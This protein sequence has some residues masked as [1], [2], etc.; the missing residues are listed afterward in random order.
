[1]NNLNFPVAVQRIGALIKWAKDQGCPKVGVMG[2]CMGGALSFAAATL[3]LGADAVVMFY[4]IPDNEYFKWSNC[5]VPV[6]GHFGR[7][8]K[9]KGFADI[10]TMNKL[11][12]VLNSVETVNE[13]HE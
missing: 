2:F 13:F 12:Q 5:K 10:E 8:D 1:M 4:G 7:Y 11:K 9:A 3:D 6:Q